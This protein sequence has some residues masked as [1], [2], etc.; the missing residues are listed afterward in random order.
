MTQKT[1]ETR[2]A[3][4]GFF[5]EIARRILPKS[6]RID[7]SI[8]PSQGSSI[9]GPEIRDNKLFLKSAEAE[10]TRLVE[11]FHCNRQSR[12]LDVGSGMGRLPIGI[13]RV[14]GEIDYTG[15]DIDKI[16]VNW[17]KRFIERY[18]P[19][20]KFR[21]LSLYNERYNKK[22]T[23]MDAGFHLDIADSAIDIIYLFSVFS[24]TTEEDMRIYL[25]EFA[26]VLDKNGFLFFTTF[27]EENVPD[28]DFN[29]EN[30]RVN[31][32]GPLH[33]VRY[34]KPYLFSILTGYGFDIQ[35]FSHA[36]EFDGQSG[37]YLRRIPH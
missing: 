30:Y 34:N 13:I 1:N 24:H 8:I 16:S 18:H 37:L 28:I 14:V 21:H 27:V 4:R 15:I 9:I 7:G 5:R 33:V 31:C 10:A 2:L 32:S 11:H 6:V 35:H 36:N 25:K 26:R 20:F 19:T 29:P 22:G 17:C 3:I 12:V 23:R